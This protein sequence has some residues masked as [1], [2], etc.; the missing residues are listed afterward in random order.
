[1][2]CTAKK[3]EAKRPEFY[4]DEIADVDHVLTTQELARMIEEKGLSFNM[5]SPESLD[6]PLGFKTGAG[7]IFGATGGVTEAALRYAAEK[8]TGE[9]LQDVRFLDVRGMEGIREASVTLNDIKVKVAVVHGLANARKVAEKIEKGECDYDFIEVMACP[10]GCIGGAGQPVSRDISVRQKRAKGLY[11]ADEM[12][13]LH[14]SQD[15]HLVQECYENT[16]GEVGGHK[17]H[18]LLHT[19]YKSRRRMQ[20]A[21]L[22]LHNGNGKKRLTISV[23]VGTSCYVKG[24]QEILKKLV[25]Y[26]EENGLSDMVNVKA[27]FCFEKCDIGP[28]VTVDK[29]MINKATFEMVVNEL[30]AALKVNA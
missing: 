15:N 5:L 28:T 18:G 25:H 8:V 10:G 29:K 4:T 22:D 17:A 16:L 20:D 14:K 24:S 7:V 23:C 6:M 11:D 30:E 3:F 9:K 21:F 26:I 1:M 19:N 27:T 12:L 2:P 13:Q